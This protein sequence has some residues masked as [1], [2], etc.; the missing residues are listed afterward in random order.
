M[1][2]S[3]FSLLR[4]GGG[5]RKNGRESVTVLTTRPHLIDLDDGQVGYLLTPPSHSRC[6]E[7]GRGAIDDHYYDHDCYSTDF[8]L[9]LTQRV[10][11]SRR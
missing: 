4:F 8:V 7:G 6:P 3:R 2:S 9:L 10:R 1:G 5:T 11:R